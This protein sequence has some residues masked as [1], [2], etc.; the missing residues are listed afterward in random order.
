MLKDFGQ[1]GVCLAGRGL[2]AA[3][4]SEELV[5]RFASE[6]RAGG[7]RRLPG[8]RGMRPMLA[9]LREASLA[10]VRRKEPSEL[11]VLIRQYDVWM[12]RERGLSAATRLRCCNTARRFLAEQAMSG[13]V[14]APGALTGQDLNAF[15]LRE[16]ARV[17]A[18]S[19]KQRVGEL[20]SLMR[21]LHL[22]GEIPLR[23][24]A[25]VPP[26]GGWR[27]AAVP[28]TMAATDIQQLLD[29][30]PREDAVGVRDYAI[31]TST[32][33]RARSLCVARAGARIGS[34]CRS[35]SAKRWSPTCPLPG[36]N[37]GS[38]SCS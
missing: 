14:L 8:P 6:L 23:L 25:A 9:Y 1:M 11:N 17:S 21:F 24:D 22:R 12:E 35:T 3:D 32:G 34:H 27:L 28:P 10:P 36:P 13:D 19:A 26:V 37:C 5:D 2:S 7:R 30:C 29:H 33:A 18:G 16:C 4:V 15:L 38:V 31:L 20:R